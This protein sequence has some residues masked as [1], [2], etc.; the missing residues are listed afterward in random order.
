MQMK[1]A[2]NRKPADVT[3]RE[4]CGTVAEIKWGPDP[5]TG[6]LIATLR[7]GHAIKGVS[8]NQSLTEGMTKELGRNLALLLRG[9]W[10]QLL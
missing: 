10:S 7:D 3:A 1:T 8:G 4:L 6:A 5:E 2:A 9:R